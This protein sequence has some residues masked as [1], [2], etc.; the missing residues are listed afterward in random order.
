MSDDVKPGTPANADKS[1]KPGKDDAK[2]KGKKG[3][4]FEKYKMWIILGGL[5][6][7]ILVFYL[8]RKNSATAST[9]ADSTASN[10]DPSTG[11]PTGSAADLA[12][13]GES[14]SQPVATAGGTADGAAGATGATGPKGAAGKTQDLWSIATEILKGRG[15]KNPTSSQIWHVRQNI[16]GLGAQHKPVPKHNPKP[17]KK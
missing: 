10:I 13:L 8:A 4:F 16:E 9:P 14:G 11:Y 7:L 1:G 5:I 17:K 12:A 15:I 6:V 2:L 3:G